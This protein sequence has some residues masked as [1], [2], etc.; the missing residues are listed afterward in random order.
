MCAQIGAFLSKF[1]SL[2]SPSQRSDVP[3]FSPYIYW[4]TNQ[5]FG[6][7]RCRSP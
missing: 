3:P 6:Q 1:D 2:K 4:H 7:T 5:T